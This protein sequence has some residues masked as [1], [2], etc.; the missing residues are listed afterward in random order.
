MNVGQSFRLAIK[1]LMASKMRALLTM[2][3][4]IIG[5]GAVII[6]TSLGNGMQQLMNDQ[7]EVM[8][9]NS[10]MV[11]TLGSQTRYVTPEQFYDLAEEYPQYIS[12]VSPQVSG[13]GVIRVSGESYS[14]TSITGVSED[15]LN[16]ESGNTMNGESL[17]QGRFLSYLDVERYENVCVIG[18]YLNE[19]AFEGDGLGG[20]VYISGI[21]YTVVGICAETVDS[22]AAS[23]DD[24]LYVPYGNVLRMNG[25]DIATTYMITSTNQIYSSVVKGLLEDMLYE[26]FQS[27]EYYF[28]ITASEMMDVLNTMVDTLMV[29]LVA[30]AAI[31]LLVGGVGIMNIM[32]VSVTERTRE[33]GIRKSLGA[34][35]RDIRG[36]FVIE[37]ATTS[38]VGGI[39]G[40]LFGV[41]LAGVA[42][43]IISSMMAGAEGYSATPGPTSVMAAFGVSVAIGI[44]FGYAPANKAAKLNPIDALRYD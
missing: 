12:G 31:S 35:G 13:A 18:S 37:A 29:V 27:D 24:F 39:I 26:S 21:P 15:F 16:S 32:L 28:V 1:S 4:I 41:A 22:T 36:Q 38:A 2:L 33:I 8:G 17:A 6:I 3:G 14:Y 9:S 30:I 25:T 7:F 10:I 19:E 23:G 44:F 11:S 40:I 5:V 20:T 42:G 43:N 34:K